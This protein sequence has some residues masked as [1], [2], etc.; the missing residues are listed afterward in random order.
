MKPVLYSWLLLT[1]AGPAWAADE[2]PVTV[3]PPVTTVDEESS[4]SPSKTIGPGWNTSTCIRI[5][6]EPWPV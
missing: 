4:A 6:P 2:L 1:M 5:P 3:L